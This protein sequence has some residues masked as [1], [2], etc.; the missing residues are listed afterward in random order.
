MDHTI[1]KKNI[2]KSACKNLPVFSDSGHQPGPEIAGSNTQNQTYGQTNGGNLLY[3]KLFWNVSRR[4]L[5]TQKQAKTPAPK[6]SSIH[7][8]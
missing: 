8:H 1:E 6:N 7:M 3:N 2:D 4:L 5:T